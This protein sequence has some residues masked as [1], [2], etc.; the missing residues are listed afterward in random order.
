MLRQKW[1]DICKGIGIIAVVLG[2]VIVR[3]ESEG[4]INI[5]GILMCNFIYSFH[6]PLLF[7][8]SGICF[9]LAYSKGDELQVQKIRTM[10]YC[11]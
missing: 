9:S 2:H 10:H 6:V 1:I 5:W 3:L 8:L 4:I 7:V 11:T